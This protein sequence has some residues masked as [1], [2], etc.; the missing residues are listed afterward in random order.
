MEP[1]ALAP[2]GMV[3]KAASDIIDRFNVHRSRFRND[4]NMI[5]TER[6]ANLARE[7]DLTLAGHLGSLY[8]SAHA[9]L[10]SISPHES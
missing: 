4:A 1:N 8:D 7:R 9:L 2:F 3:R 5:G 6:L 10:P